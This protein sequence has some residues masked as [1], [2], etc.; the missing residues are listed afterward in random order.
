MAN[1]G[2]RIFRAGLA[3]DA[4]DSPKDL[5]RFQ[6]V[7]SKLD[8]L[9]SYLVCKCARHPRIRESFSG[10]KTGVQCP[11]GIDRQS[12][13]QLAF[14]QKSA[15]ELDPDGCASFTACEGG[16]DQWNARAIYRLQSA[17]PASRLN[18]QLLYGL[19]LST[20]RQKGVDTVEK[21]GGRPFCGM[22]WLEKSA[23][24]GRQSAPAH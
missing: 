21:L 24:M 11:C 6:H 4:W 15:D 1:W 16:G 13:H 12:T 9:R 8:E 19:D 10:G 5:L 7:E 22:P 17:A 14:L 18:P 2:M 20:E 23:R 3:E